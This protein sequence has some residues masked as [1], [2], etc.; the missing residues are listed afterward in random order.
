MANLRNARFCWN[1]GTVRNRADGAC[2]PLPDWR[3]RVS[4]SCLGKKS[5]FLPRDP[6]HT[7]TIM[8]SWSGEAL[9]DACNSLPTDG[10]GVIISY[11]PG[12]CHPRSD[13]RKKGSFIL[14]HTLRVQMSRW[15][16]SWPHC[17]SSQEDRH[18]CTV[19]FFIPSLRDFGL[20][21]NAAHVQGHLPSLV[22][23]V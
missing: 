20:R 15:G 10:C 19:G 1:G 7:D 2:V 5:C 3:C 11:S 4:V 18:G 22:D 13:E 12:C 9:G 14:S 17:S 21:K 23:H 6:P 8:T 16:W